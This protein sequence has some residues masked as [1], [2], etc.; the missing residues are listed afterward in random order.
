MYDVA[1]IGAGVIGTMIAR[2]LTKYNLSVCVLER[3]NDVANGATKANSGIVHAG[4]DAHSGSLKAKFNVL[5]SKM[6]KGVTEELGVKYRVNGSLVVGFDENDL[7]ILK[8]LLNQGQKN[9]VE[10]LEI[11]DSD[12]LH[13]LEPNLSEKVKYALYA[14]TGAIVCPYELCIAAMG[15]AMDNGADLKLNFEVSDIKIE[16]DK[17]TVSSDS[18]E[19]T[20]KYI[21]NAAGLYSDEIARAAGDCSIDVHP[22]RGEYIL[23][24]NECGDITNCTIFGVPSEKGKGILMS[25]TVDG[26]FLLGPTSVDMTDKE[27][28]ETTAEGFAK[29][30]GEA[31]EK[32]NNL[33]LN[34]TITSFCG[35][36]AA[37][38]TGDFIINTYKDR[39]VNVAGIESPGLSASPAIAK[40]V[41]E[42][43][44]ECGLELFENQNFNPHRKP[45]HYFKEATIGE[46]NEIIKKHP[47]YG[48][49][50]CRCE[51]VTEGEIIEAIR[52]NPPARDIDAVKRRTRSG[53]G[54]CQGGFCMPYVAE[55][56]ARELNIPFD[57]VTKFGGKSVIVT[58]K[59]K[60][61]EK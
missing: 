57:E 31:R 19:V 16:K 20:A 37:G 58:S 36:R 17:I 54:R 21:V 47:E 39:V 50:I 4:F 15:N 49:V 46:K 35:L 10:K 14:P 53:M 44:G 23:L 9:G 52:N 29:I 41:L 26:N 55:I 33:P 11:L 22:R 34:K 27:N 18:D 42:L 56:I 5:G 48:R 51:G 28:K 24:D 25:P 12:K 30:I 38:N 2:E 32:I 6:M 8:N 13:K 60:E 1:V 43:L 45:N 59:T 7:E 61:I 40:Y 3:E